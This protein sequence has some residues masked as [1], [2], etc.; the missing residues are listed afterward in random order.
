MSAAR[1][2]LYYP[3]PAPF[4]V[5]QAALTV[6]GTETVSVRGGQTVECWVVAAELPGGVTRLWIGKANGEIVQFASGEG[7]SVFWFRRPGAPAT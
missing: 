6:T 2:D 1:L 7:E 4:G 5:R 3:F